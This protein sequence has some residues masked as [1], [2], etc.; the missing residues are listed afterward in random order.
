MCSSQELVSLLEEER[1]RFAGLPLLQHRLAF[2]S[3]I[4]WRL[5]E[6][7]LEDIESAI[8]P[9]A[10]CLVVPLS[11]GY[12]ASCGCIEAILGLF[13]CGSGA[14]ACA[15]LGQVRIQ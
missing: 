3:K 14:W 2:A 12:H 8:A 11:L 1:E 4:Q 6:I 13:S 15:C 5:L 10:P 9:R 7:F